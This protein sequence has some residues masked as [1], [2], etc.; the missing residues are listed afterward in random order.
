MSDRGVNSQL[1]ALVTGGEAKPNLNVQSG[2]RS[3]TARPQAA[4]AGAQGERRVMTRIALCCQ[5]VM[6]EACDK[7]LIQCDF[8]AALTANESAGVQIAARFEPAVY[9]HLR[10]IA[11]GAS[12]AYGSI[13]ANDLDRAA[14]GMLLK[15]DDFHARYLTAAFATNNRQVIAA[16]EDDSLRQLATSWGYTQIM[17]YHVVGVNGTVR[18]LIDPPYHYHLAVELLTDFARQYKLDPQRDFEPLFRCWN[19]GSPNGKTFDPNYVANGLRRMELYRE[20]LAA[21]AGSVQPTGKA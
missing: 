6:L 1:S 21:Q 12:T 16:L 13:H 4:V 3:A 2:L 15:G 7:G 9:R 20:V 14:Q 11:A 5:I 18:N 10:D 17:G 19:S 8:L